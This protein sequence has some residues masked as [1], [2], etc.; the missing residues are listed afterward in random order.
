[1]HEQGCWLRKQS[2]RFVVTKNDE[3]VLDIPVTK[4]EQILVFG[5]CFLSP[6]ARRFCLHE[7]IPV[8][9]LSAHGRYY[10]ELLSDAR[11]N[12]A[13]ETLQYMRSI[14]EA[15]HVDTA[16]R[17]V[18]AKLGNTR[19]LLQRRSDCHALIPGVIDDLQQLMKSVAQATSVNE[20]RGYEGK[21]AALYFGVFDQLIQ[22]DDFA[23]TTR[24]RRPPPDPVNAM[25]SFGYT[26]L[27]QNVRSLLHL[28]RLNPYFGSL[29]RGHNA[30]PALASD[31]V[32]EFRGLIDRMVL[33]LINRGHMSA[34]DFL[35]KTDEDPERPSPCWI[36]PDA[37]RR[38]IQ[39][40]E[41]LMHR[42]VT[43][44]GTSYVVSYR[45]C[46]DLQVRAYIRHLEGARPYEPF[47]WR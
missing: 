46:I 16:R 7:N 9:F 32:E 27:F 37:R 22:A 2:G 28:H 4:V 18:T 41:R 12:V 34:E 10:G 40:F 29:H 43:H 19:S 36:R 26:L 11:T 20:I 8:T 13:R 5:T 1:M 15:F 23:F 39:R 42:E 35:N 44:P 47:R 24:Q 17:I 33:G 45:R 21:G 25:L 6:A 3:L 31:L 38:F 14:D 30:H